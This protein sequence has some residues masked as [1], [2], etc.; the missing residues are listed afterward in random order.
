ML[1]EDNVIPEINF[2][3]IPTNI[4]SELAEYLVELELVLRDSLRGSSYLS[5]M[6]EDGIIGN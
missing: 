3:V 6:F 2:P 5:R 4:D 1:N